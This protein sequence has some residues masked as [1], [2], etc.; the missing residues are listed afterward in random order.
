MTQV[1]AM[2]VGQGGT[3]LPEDR[4]VNT[5]HF[6]TPAGDSA[7]N[8]DLVAD[9]LKVFYGSVGG[10]LQEYVQRA[11]EIR[12]Y[13]MADAEPRE[14]TIWPFT[15]PARIQA[16]GLP[17]ECCVCLSY[18]GDPPV[19]PRRRGR[20]YIGPLIPGVVENA[21]TTVPPQIGSTF[22]TVLAAAG[23]TLSEAGVGWSIYSTVTST[24]IPITG[25][26]VDNATDIQRRRGSQATTRTVWGPA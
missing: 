1:R 3:M 6:V 7:T 15:L 19:T 5:F 11:A 23:L 2:F 21:T 13:D 22:R 20:I 12:T 18:H 4:F 9:A 24:F 8:Q 17:E 10:Y 14:P 16:G 25:G 26:W